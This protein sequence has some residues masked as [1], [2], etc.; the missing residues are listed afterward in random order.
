MP[1]A[2]EEAQPTP[3]TSA[4]D[5][6]TPEVQTPAAAG[7][8]DSASIAAKPDDKGAT[9]P[10][11][12][13]A[14]TTPTESRAVKLKDDEEIPE[15]ADLIELSTKAL[16][17]RLARHTKR[18]LRE[19]FGTDDIDS[20][21]TKLSRLDELEAKEEENR[22]AALDEKTRLEEDKARAEARA[23]AAETR[24]KEEKE[25]R[26]A[27]KAENRIVTVA[28]KVMD[29][30]YIDQHLDQFAAHLKKHFTEK[31]LRKLK[32]A[33]I[34]KWFADQ[35]TKKPKFGADYEDKVKAAA[36]SASPP[37]LKKTPITNGVKDNEKPSTKSA[38]GAGEKKMKPG[39]S[40]SMNSAEARAKAAQ[41]GYRW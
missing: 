21:K 3:A 23:E 4:D 10:A 6:A 22:R 15:N 32:D 19:R 8:K 18:E 34:E 27:G 26:I 14:G 25:T 31:Q 29:P 41:D 1:K 13:A 16:K 40:D 7:T 17:S 24:L 33:D 35:V 12:A 38:T 39:Q 28:K 5:V 11:I 30:D 36:S 20:I 9:P 2:Q 37:P